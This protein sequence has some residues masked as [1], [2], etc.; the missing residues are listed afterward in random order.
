MA[1]RRERQLAEIAALVASGDRDRA[2][3]LACEHLADFPADAE[4]L[5]LLVTGSG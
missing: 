3:G 2:S 4:L 1:G 5:A